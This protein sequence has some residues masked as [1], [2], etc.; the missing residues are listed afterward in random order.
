MPSA[1]AIAPAYGVYSLNRPNR[2]FVRVAGSNVRATGTGSR[3]RRRE[4]FFSHRA[5]DGAFHRLRRF[6][7]AERD[8]RAAKCL[9]CSRCMTSSAAND[10]GMP[11]RHRRVGPPTATTRRGA[12]A[13]AIA[14]RHA[15]RAR[16]CAIGRRFWRRCV[17][18]CRPAAT[19]LHVA[20]GSGEHA[21]HFA[22]ALAPLRWQPT[23]TDPAALRS[24][25]ASA[26]QP[27]RDPRR[28]T[29]K[30]AP[31]APFPQSVQGGRAGSRGANAGVSP[32]RI[33]RGIEVDASAH[34]S[35]HLRGAGAEREGAAARAAARV[36][37][38]TRA[39][40][41]DLFAPRGG[42]RG[43]SASAASPTR[44]TSG[45]WNPSAR[46]RPRHCPS[47]P[48]APL[49][50]TSARDTTCVG[51]R[52]SPASRISSCEADPPESDGG[53]PKTLTSVPTSVVWTSPSR[54]R[55]PA[56]ENGRKELRCP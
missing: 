43:A 40:D 30:R 35:D 16:A 21:C 49:L 39:I 23:D 31:K 15:S 34:A 50:R 25:I 38:G 48:S 1:H 44:C 5:F 10:S 28:A 9:I 42:K 13:V 26:A 18:I 4:P 20:S 32:R 11:K 6:S 7:R 56:P 12:G 41:E 45:S 19:V 51:S 22:A 37:A 2:L 17:A 29:S 36:V 24:D 27:P 54:P 3:R 33:A 8:E 14:S 52:A 55:P 46:A 47:A 53:A